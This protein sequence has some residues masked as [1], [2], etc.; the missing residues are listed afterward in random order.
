M[1]ISSTVLPDTP[2]TYNVLI[3]GIMSCTAIY[4]EFDG[5]Q[6]IIPEWFSGRDFNWWKN[7]E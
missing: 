1:F 7:E 6:W 4:Y 3:D 5:E 2:G